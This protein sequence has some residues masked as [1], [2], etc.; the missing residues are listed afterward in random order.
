MADAGSFN[1]KGYK[2]MKRKIKLLIVLFTL[3]LYLMPALY[4]DFIAFNNAEYPQMYLYKNIEWYPS[5]TYR[6]KGAEY[7]E[8]QYTYY[9]W[10]YKYR[11]ESF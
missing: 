10:C 2:F 6:D 5:L 3:I 8:G 9:G 11:N 7:I 1:S 4:F